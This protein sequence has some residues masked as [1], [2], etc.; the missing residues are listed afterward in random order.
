MPLRQ[1]QLQTL[2]WAGLALLFLVLIY[3]LSPILTP[4]L[5][6]AIFAYILNPGVNWLERKRVPRSVGALIMV[7]GLLIV[8]LLVFL[9]VT[10]L[11]SK[12]ANQLYQQMPALMGKLDQFV[13]PRLNAWFGWEVQFD[14]ESI[15]SYIG[16]HWQSADGLTARLLA[17]LKLGGLAL[18]GVLGNLILIPMVLFYL[19]V[20]WPRLIEAIDKAIPRRWHAYVSG[21]AREIDTVLAEFLRGQLGVMGLLII[22]Y[23]VTLWIGRLDFALPI[24]IITGGLV[25]VPYL[26]FGTGLVLA[27][28]VAVLMPNLTHALIVVA[29][30]FGFGQVLESF[31]LTPRIVG[32]RIGLHPLAV[33]F[34]LLAFGQ[35]F[36]FFGVLLALPASAVLL[37]GLRRLRVAYLESS[38]YQA[39]TETAIQLTESFT[40]SS[41]P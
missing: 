24:A 7:V 29:V 9:I 34:A 16:E 26:G 23:A 22:Y 25:F 17:S 31:V 41:E 36:G 28:I 13:A 19:L 3:Y 18:A 12:Q 5:A 4:F 20:D 15:K 27:L 2:I 21:I 40:E 39:E 38:F 6:G 8:L 32:K 35:I 30:V 33:I 1:E 37:V 10:P 14:F 11:I